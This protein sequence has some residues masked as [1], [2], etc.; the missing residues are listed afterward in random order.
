MGFAPGPHRGAAPGPARP[1]RTQGHGPWTH[2]MRFGPEFAVLA[3]FL[4]EFVEEG[5]DRRMAARCFFPR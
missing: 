5:Q 2:F 4:G 1:A 3:Q